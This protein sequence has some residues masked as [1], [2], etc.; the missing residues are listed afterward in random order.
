M[1]DEIFSCWAIIALFGKTQVAGQLS[2]QKFGNASMFRVEIPEVITEGTKIPAHTR[3]IA[4]NAV[5]DINPVTE[6]MARAHAQQLQVM[7]LNHFDMN[8]IFQEKVN[9]LIKKGRLSLPEGVESEE[10]PE[11]EDEDL[12]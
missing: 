7:P 3:F 2:E 9:E 4:I 5:F 12:M 8:Q 1:A 10:L 6:E 11:D